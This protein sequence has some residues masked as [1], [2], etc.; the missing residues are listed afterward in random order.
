MQIFKSDACM[1]VR[2]IPYFSL[3]ISYFEL[4]YLFSGGYACVRECAADVCTHMNSP[5]VRVFIRLTFLYLTYMY[6]L[7]YFCPPVSLLPCLCVRPSIYLTAFMHA[8]VEV[9]AS[10]HSS[11]HPFVCVHECFILAWVRE[12]LWA[13][14]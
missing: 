2:D 8:Y 11:V 1:P 14:V 6:M 12:C 4:R 3:K 5:F 13:W 7:K 9:C 10:V